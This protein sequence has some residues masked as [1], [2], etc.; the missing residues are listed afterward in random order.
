MPDGPIHVH[1]TAVVIGEAGVLIRGP[2]GAGKSSLA[3]RLLAEAGQRGR[4]ARLVGDDRVA[5]S[6]ANG[7]LL[8]RP[9]PVIAG[10]IERRTL[11]IATLPFESGCV[12]RLVVDLAPFGLDRLLDQRPAPIRLLGHVDLPLLRLAPHRSDLGCLFVFQE[13]AQL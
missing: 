3:L 13:L 8:A 1:A 7:A 11:P 10:Q 6:E 9:H 2:S 5:L 4:F 12:L